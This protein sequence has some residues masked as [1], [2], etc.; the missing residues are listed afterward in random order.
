[1][2]ELRIVLAAALAAAIAIATRHVP[3]G[4]AGTVSA[5]ATAQK[6]VSDTVIGLE[7]AALDR[8]G[9]GDPQGY[10]ETYAP[11]ITYFDPFTD[12]R[13][14]GIDAIKAMLEP[15]TGKVKIDRYEMLNPRVQQSGDVAVLSYNLVAHTHTPDGSPRT[16]R[17]NS[18][19]V[20]RRTAGKWR[21]I[22][23]HW[24]FTK[25][26]LTQVGTPGE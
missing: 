19:E 17:W 25:P 26:E 9:R 13:I 12:K 22:H 2:K 18:T 21:I 8:W 4:E 10:I 20:Y 11:G 16:V 23:N 15:I 1:M 14:D 24:S 7:R 6:A 5:T 3:D